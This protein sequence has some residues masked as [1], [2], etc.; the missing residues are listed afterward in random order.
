[1]NSSRK[2]GHFVKRYWFFLLGADIAAIILTGYIAASWQAPGTPDPLHLGYV[3]V[4]ELILL[5]ILL[6]RA[7]YLLPGARSPRP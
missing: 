7:I 1:M 6:A 3:L 5:V 4:V 2:L